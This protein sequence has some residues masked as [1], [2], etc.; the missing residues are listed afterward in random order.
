MSTTTDKMK[1]LS[2]NAFIADVT[3][4]VIFCSKF[5]HH[6]LQVSYH[7]TGIRSF[8]SRFNDKIVRYPLF[9]HKSFDLEVSSMGFLYLFS[10][11]SKIWRYLNVIDSSKGSV[12]RDAGDFYLMLQEILHSHLLLVS[13]L[14]VTAIIGEVQLI[15]R[16]II[17]I[18]KR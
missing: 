12:F 1:S 4:F 6:Y 2:V 10:D 8:V 5:L 7:Y 14:I 3:L 15:L 18:T 11:L 17:I 9:L 16:G 13:I